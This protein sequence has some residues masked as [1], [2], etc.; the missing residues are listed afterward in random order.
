MALYLRDFLHDTCLLPY[1]TAS[2]TYN[3]LLD[4]ADALHAHARSSP[5]STS[6][7][8]LP[9]WHTL[10]QRHLRISAECADTY[11]I[12]FAQN[13]CA[14]THPDPQPDALKF[15]LLLFNQL[16]GETAARGEEAGRD[17][18]FFVGEGVHARFD[19]R[20]TGGGGS[21]SVGPLLSASSSASSLA[22][23]DASS[24][25][26]SPVGSP[27]FSRKRRAG[28]EAAV[29]SGLSTACSPTTTRTTVADPPRPISSR[30]SYPCELIEP[31]NRAAAFW[32]ANAL[33]WLSLVFVT[34]HGRSLVPDAHLLDHHA[35]KPLKLFIPDLTILD[36]LFTAVAPPPSFTGD[37]DP[38]T[39]LRALFTRWMDSGVVDTE[40]DDAR[41]VDE[42]MSGRSA[43]LAVEP[44]VALFTDFCEGLGGGSGASLGLLDRWISWS[45]ACRPHMYRKLS[46]HENGVAVG[47]KEV[48]VP[49]REDNVMQ[50][51][52]LGRRVIIVGAV[53]PCLFR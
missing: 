10:A 40:S 3:A 12:V 27:S 51:K 2:F 45:V 52:L 26:S 44:A 25:A 35:I 5:S 14:G 36:F 13:L 24:P 33:K 11:Y 4:L 19:L 6:T 43:H 29:D 18:Q 7:L 31:R 30:F 21:R 38:R 34:L 28:G 15:L 16:Q 32:R 48:A 22:S 53:S 8:P 20:R 9:L 42:I 37:A 46:F 41:A 50:G 47:F 23:S 17:A 1:P 39:R 49:F